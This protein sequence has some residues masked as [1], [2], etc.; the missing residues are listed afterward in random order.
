MNRWS[1]VNSILDAE[2]DR[3]VKAKFGEMK[4]ILGARKRAN[5][6]NGEAK[7]ISAS[8]MR[9]EA[10]GRVVNKGKKASRARV[11]QGKWMGTI[12][13]LSAAQKADAKKVREQRGF[14]AAI[15]YVKRLKKGAEA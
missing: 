2:V 5:G 4:A 3:A 10:W 9:D 6:H 1:R 8:R 7:P 11:Q 14:R 15:A 12:R 13:S